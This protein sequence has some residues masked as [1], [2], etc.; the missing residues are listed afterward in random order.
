MAEETVRNFVEAL[1]KLESQGDLEGIVGLF[2]DDCEVG[3]N[4][5]PEPLHGK[6]G[7]H[8]FWATYRETLGAARSTFRSQIVTPERAA[9]EWT[10][11]GQADG[12]AYRYE[13]VSVLEIDGG[14]ITRFRAFF[15]AH[16]LG[17]QL[18]AAP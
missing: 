5:M 18:E 12:K 11:Q 9:L 13:G 16:D 2:A 10:T 3:N 4:G 14:R 6:E 1:E 17:R 7:A 8:R 15:D